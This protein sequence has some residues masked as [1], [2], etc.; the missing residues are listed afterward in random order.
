MGCG[1]TKEEEPAQTAPQEAAPARPAPGGSWADSQAD[2]SEPKWDGDNFCAK[3]KN[4]AGEGVDSSI[5]VCN[6]GDTFGNSNGNFN[7]EERAMPGGSYKDSMD[8]D[9]T[10]EG[11]VLKAK[12]KNEA[13]ELCDAE[14]NIEEHPYGKE[15]GNANGVFA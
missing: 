13:V 11:S 6:A 1:G 12:L 9:A 2:G 3:L 15:F 5:R 8:G 14:V 10:L 4:E 7:V